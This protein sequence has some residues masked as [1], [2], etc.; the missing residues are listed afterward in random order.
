MWCRR[1]GVEEAVVG[2]FFVRDPYR[3]LGKLWID[4]RAARHE[5]VAGPYAPRRG[6]VVIGD[7]GGS[8]TLAHRGHLLD[9]PCSTQDQP[10]PASR[11]IL[12]ALAFEPR[13]A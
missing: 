6:S 2:G 1:N 7:G 8:T 12:S 5:P 4:G 13:G 3:P 11:E 10:G 9:R